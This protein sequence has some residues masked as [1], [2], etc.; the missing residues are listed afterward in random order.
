MTTPPL[1]RSVDAV[2]VPVPDLDAGLAFYRDHLGHRLLW[3]NDD[4]GQA[5]LALATGDTELV[6]STRAPYAP[7]W[8]VSSVEDAATAMAEAGGRC[9]AGPSDIPVGRLSVVAD[10]FGNE[11]V[12]VD[13]SKGRYLVDDS[14]HVTGVQ[15]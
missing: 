5:G 10:A 12:L 6:L 4:I 3:R 13:L 8:L 11:L 15:P 2:T 1:L 7:T 9:V 14:G